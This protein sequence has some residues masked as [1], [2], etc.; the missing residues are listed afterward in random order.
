[1]FFGFS[2]QGL[3]MLPTRIDQNNWGLNFAAP[4]KPSTGIKKFTRIPI[5]TPSMSAILKVFYMEKPTSNLD[6]LNRPSFGQLISFWFVQAIC[7][8]CWNLQPNYIRGENTTRTQIDVRTRG[9]WIHNMAF[10]RAGQ[11]MCWNLI[12]TIYPRLP[13][14][15]LSQNSPTP[16]ML[17]PSSFASSAQKVVYLTQFAKAN[18]DREEDTRRASRRFIW[19]SQIG[20]SDSGEVPRATMGRHGKLEC[21]IF[22]VQCCIA[23]GLQ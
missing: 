9:I 7:T 15:F 23:P 16:G 11:V 6:A 19:Q 17:C 4:A 20:K 8:M 21:C 13:L 12:N 14:F 2:S 5:L 3:G 10:Y 1:M 22:T 18:E